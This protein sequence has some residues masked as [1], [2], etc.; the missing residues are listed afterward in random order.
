M[1]EPVWI[2]TDGDWSN[3]ASWDTAAVP[4]SSDT[5]IFDGIASVVSVTSGLNQSA[6][7]LAELVVEPEYTG[8]FA[9]SGA[10]LQIDTVQL[11]HR[12]SGAMYIQGG[13]GV[14]R[15]AVL[16][17]PRGSLELGG[18]AM[19]LF[20]LEGNATILG[21]LAS[22]TRLYVLGAQAR[23]TVLSGSATTMPY[24]YMIDGTVACS[25]NISTLATVNG[26]TLTLD[27]RYPAGELSIDGGRVNFKCNTSGP[28]VA[29]IT[30]L[31]GT[32][33]MAPGR[34]PVTVA[35]A[36]FAPWAT[37]IESPAAL[38]TWTDLIDLRDRYP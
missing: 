13:A 21:S 10:P 35:D 31:N 5:V 26:G 38:V 22:I 18:V 2:S 12:G 14:I 36:M 25:R 19:S 29:R 6:V 23:V 17:N 27:S 20:V 7:D 3:T 16:D 9:T 28:D 8:D 37:I 34:K 15:N 1:S 24:I 4:V 32:L 11:T 33:H 30:V